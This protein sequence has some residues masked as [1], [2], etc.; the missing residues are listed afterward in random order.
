MTDRAY[1]PRLVRER[2]DALELRPSKVLGQNFMID[3]NT[4]RLVA[5]AAE[6]S[7]S[8]HV[9]EIGP[10]LGALTEALE[11]EVDRLTLIEKDRR[12]AAW[13]RD[14]YVD[15]PAVEVLEADALDGSLVRSLQAGAR[16][17]VSNLPYATGARILVEALHSANPPDRF[18]VTIQKDVAERLAASVN[19]KAYGPLAVWAQYRHEVTIARTIGARCFYPTPKV[20]SALVVMQK[21][22]APGRAPRDEA[23]FRQL[24][25]AS[26]I[27][28][29][30]TM[31]NVLSGWTKE[32]PDLALE[33]AGVSTGARPAELTVDDW[34]RLSDAFAGD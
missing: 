27:H 5:A 7:P 6:L 17:L 22:S 12:L 18:V 30:K 16:K 4:V 26:F 15:H 14:R 33:Q 2:L 34:V 20:E 19:Q 29:R 24:V 11:T 31:H 3:G 10:G 1:S 23:L 25:K 21:R 32:E 13:L 28:R 8:D 9:V